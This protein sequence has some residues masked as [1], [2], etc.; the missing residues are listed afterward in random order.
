MQQWFSKT[1]EYDP[2][3]GYWLALV[4]MV[5]HGLH[6]LEAFLWPVSGAS[7][8]HNGI[9]SRGARC[10]Q[11]WPLNQMDD[12]R[13][14]VVVFHATSAVHRWD[15]T[16]LWQRLHTSDRKRNKVTAMVA[17]TAL[18]CPMTWTLP[19]SRLL[20]RLFT[21]AGEGQPQISKCPL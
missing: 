17:L 15:T 11:L 1:G 12:G 18:G 10:L 20:R 8:T 16:G 2:R 3:H 6:V 14:F 13:V 5:L 9:R 21:Q 7:A 4:L 19:S